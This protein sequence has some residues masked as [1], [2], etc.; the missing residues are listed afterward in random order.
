MPSTQTRRK[1]R[2]GQFL[3]SL[4]EAAGM[5][6]ERIAGLLR[7]SQATISKIENGYSLCNFSELGA[8]LAFYGAT[9]EQSA[10]ARA[11][12]DDAKQDSK[13]VEHS[14][15]SPP[16]YRA[17]IR[18]EADAESV[19]S[20]ATEVVPGLLQTPRYSEAVQLAAH[21]FVDRTISA[22]AVNTKRARQKRL[23]E[24][25]PLRLHALI[26]ESVL[27]RVVGGAEV[28]AE[29]L[30]HI[31]DEAA[32][33][34]VI[35]QVIPFEIGAYGTSSGSVTI[36]GFSADDDPDAVYLEYP[37]GGEW[38]ENESDV[39][40]FGATFADVAEACPAPAESVQWIRAR[41]DELEHRWTS[42]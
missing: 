38:V 19:R 34:N 16:K 39:Q 32:R 41:A 28:M 29:Q 8:M 35:V 25:V 2:L 14:S 21:R 22:R 27:R 9:E 3:L 4:R 30:R 17:Y 7:K 13:R 10:E 23:S 37:G 42:A 33:E 40:L 36:V 6:H 5:N 20:L 18:A 26:D 12:W 1:R 24:G 15:S 31:V 11:M